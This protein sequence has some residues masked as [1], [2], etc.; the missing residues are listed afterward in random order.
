MSEQPASKVGATSE[1][2]TP[3]AT[4]Q[5]ED[6]PT[7]VSDQLSAK[8]TT[9]SAVTGG[10]PPTNATTSSTLCAISNRDP[11]EPESEISKQEEVCP[12]TPLYEDLWLFHHPQS[13][14]QLTKNGKVF[15]V[16]KQILEPRSPF[17]K[18]KFQAGSTYE[19][20]WTSVDCMTIINYLNLSYGSHF[21][22]GTASKSALSRTIEGMACVAKL[23]DLASKVQD[24][25][26]MSWALRH[27]PSVCAEGTCQWASESDSRKTMQWLETAFLH[28]DP[29]QGAL[30]RD[31]I[32]KKVCKTC[33]VE[34]FS[35]LFSAIHHDFLRPICVEYA[36]L[37][38]R[39]NLSADSAELKHKNTSLPP[40]A[41]KILTPTPTPTSAA[42]A[43]VKL[44]G[45]GVCSNT[46]SIAAQNLGLF[47]SSP[48]TGNVKVSSVT[49]NP[50]SPNTAV[51]PPNTGTAT[52]SMFGGASNHANSGNSSSAVLTP[53][54]S[55]NPS[56]FT[57]GGASQ[58]AN[59]RPVTTGPFGQTFAGSDSNRSNHKPTNGTRNYRRG[60]RGQ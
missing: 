39:D 13:I 60:G 17:W 16:H 19:L 42:L 20:P 59:S 51:Q 11:T 21:R 8:P 30:C 56:A 35:K 22:I 52:M 43:N 14:V 37:S 27:F 24:T 41:P 29:V 54:G 18:D 53:T 5:K 2:N 32:I 40:P 23:H 1:L 10:Q 58:P 45:S 34:I 55:T 15:L 48:S 3:D 12:T 47:G 25:G 33:P 46:Q 50:A 38:V 57:F 44:E 49:N 26:V 31:L 4:H 7:D 6:T 28:W 36:R 9:M